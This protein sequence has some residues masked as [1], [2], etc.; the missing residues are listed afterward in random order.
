MQPQAK[1]ARLEL[2]LSI[3]DPGS[4]QWLSYAGVMAIAFGTKVS[5]GFV[6]LAITMGPQ[7]TVG[8]ARGG[9]AGAGAGTGGAMASIGAFPALGRF[10]GRFALEI[11]C[12]ASAG[13]PACVQVYQGPDPLLAS[14]LKLPPDLSASPTALAAAIGE[15]AGG[16][17]NT[18]SVA[19]RFDDVTFDVG[20]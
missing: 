7:F 19:P 4:V 15:M 11:D 10:A 14:C 12:G 6:G 2:D 1:R 20:Y 18:G 17:G 3:D 9:D 16:F 8:W 5:D 13:D